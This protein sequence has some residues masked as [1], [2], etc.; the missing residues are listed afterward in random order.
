MSKNYSILLLAGLV[1]APAL[2]AQGVAPGQDVMVFNDGERLVGKFVRSNG[3]TA[4]FKSDAIGEITVDW[5][6]VKELQSSQKFA[7]IPK[8][9]VL[10]RGAD[11]SNVPQG[12]IA[13][14]EQKITVTPAPGQPNPQT[15]TVA[16]VDTDHLIDTTTFNNELQHNPSFFADWGG[17]VTAG[18][19]LVESTQESRTFNVAINLVRTVPDAD[20]LRRRNRTIVNFST[21]YGTLSQPE[22]PTVKTDIYHAGIERDEYFSSAFYGFAQAAFDHNFSQGLDLQ[23][24]YGAGIGWSVIKRPN[25]SLDLKAGVTYIRQDFAGASTTKSLEGS[26]FEED[27][28]R[29]LMRGIKF[30]Q[31]LIIIPAWNNT[32]ALTA[33]GSALLTMPIYKR[34]NFSIGTIDN[35]LH[36]PPEGFKKNSFQATMGLTYSL[37]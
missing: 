29:G 6:K 32:D 9:V 25:E 23:Q 15:Q 28:Q 34:M 2:F 13:V 10:K 31:T 16:V 22:T 17:T 12:T 27:Y 11:T 36:D 1:A 33:S 20:W 18:A 19:A 4:V 21:A 35:Y 8:N 5:S 7:V 3:A 24:T 14:A 37:R 30:N 26:V